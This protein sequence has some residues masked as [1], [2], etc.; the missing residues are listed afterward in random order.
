MAALVFFVTLSGWGASY[1]GLEED[2]LRWVAVGMIAAA[3]FAT[4]VAERHLAATASE[5]WPESKFIVPLLRLTLAV[6]FLSLPSL[7][8]P[9]VTLSLLVN[10]PAILVILVAIEFLLHGFF[11][12]GRNNPI[13]FP[14]IW[15][16]VFVIYNQIRT[17]LFP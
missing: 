10:L 11:S 16:T 7:V 9:S 17:F 13:A 3:I 15:K 6:Q 2:T 14:A 4:L 1:V 12:L 8:F 5:A